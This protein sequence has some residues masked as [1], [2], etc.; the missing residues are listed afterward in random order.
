MEK[1]TIEYINK[2]VASR[3]ECLSTEYIDN[4]HK[5]LFRCK[6]CGST[7]PQTASRALQGKINPCCLINKKKDLEIIKEFCT[8]KNI[9]FLD[10]TFINVNH[11]HRWQCNV[12]LGLIETKYVYLKENKNVCS[13]CYPIKFRSFDEIRCLVE[14]KGYSLIKIGE[15]RRLTLFC[16]KCSKEFE[17]TLSK[18]VNNNQG[19]TACFGQKKYDLDS[20]KKECLQKN[21]ALLSE[22]YLGF[23]DFHVFKCLKCGYEWENTYNHFHRHFKGCAKCLGFHSS[24]EIELKEVLEKLTGVAWRSDRKILKG[25]EIDAYH[26]DFL[27]AFEFCGIYY[28]SEIF[29]KNNYHYLKMKL[30]LD[31]NIKLI[32]IFEDEWVHQRD[33]VVSRIKSLLSLC[34]IREFARNLKIREIPTIVSSNFYDQA[35]LQGKPSNTL[36]SFGLYKNESLLGAISLGR[37]PRDN[38]PNQICLTRLCFKQDV[39]ILG[40][41]EKLFKY[42]KL[43][44]SAKKYVKII[45]WSDNRWSFGGVYSRLKFELEKELPPDYS[46][47]QNN[48]IKRIS[49]SLLRKNKDERLLKT[50][51]H[52]LRLKQK[53]YRIYDC[54]KKRWSFAL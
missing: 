12:C 11:N 39:Y 10:E 20:I 53:R 35:H 15:K 33:K 9:T 42:C 41:A 34:S 24:G 17:I 27:Y 14:S 4:K 3:A 1:L 40:G 46:Y 2:S 51:E 18:I 28:H 32:T 52:E 36:V 49:K 43:W 47:T 5:L 30:C 45:S 19:C 16:K 29:K 21:C 54:G 7:F 26:P 13:H 37:H 48:S 22:N 31:N 44:A 6:V 50:T 25:F 8:K 38:S 23:D